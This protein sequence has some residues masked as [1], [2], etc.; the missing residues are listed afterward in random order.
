MKKT[1]LLAITLVMI[2]ATASLAQ[3]RWSI[4]GELAFPQGD[5]GDFVGAGLG[6]YGRY[7]GPINNNLTWMATTG[8]THFFEK[9]NWTASSVPF[10]GGIKYYVNSAFNGFWFGGELGFNI[11]GVKYH[12]DGVFN[13]ASDSETRFSFAPQLGYHISNVDFALR[14]VVIE[15]FNYISLR[16]AYVFGG[17]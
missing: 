9:N 2:S 8:Y 4:G 13:D 6:V 17:K 16:A 5:F 10:N 12:N 3:G 1:L 7:E 14:Y 15:D 11:I